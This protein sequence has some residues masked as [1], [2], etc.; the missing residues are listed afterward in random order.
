MW[1]E[2]QSLATL[3]DC[4][5]D[6]SQGLRQVELQKCAVVLPCLRVKSAEEFFR[7]ALILG[8]R[9]QLNTSRRSVQESKTC[10]FVNF[11]VVLRATKGTQGCEV[12][13]QG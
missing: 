9:L 12:H 10:I 4:Q 6:A 13:K 3:G 11:C 1:C 2:A 8:L 7:Q 5:D